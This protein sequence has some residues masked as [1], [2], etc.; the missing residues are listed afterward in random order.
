MRQKES[1][2]ATRTSDLRAR[3]GNT[4]LVELKAGRTFLAG[5]D[6]AKNPLEMQSLSLRAGIPY[7]CGCNAKN[8][9][10]LGF[11][12]MIRTGLECPKS[13]FGFVVAAPP[14]L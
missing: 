12:G 6:Q 8:T 10:L 9:S 5:N 1:M 3:L 11:F 13:R 4:R 2:F 14:I 7:G